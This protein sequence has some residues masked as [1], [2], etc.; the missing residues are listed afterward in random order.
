MRLISIA[1]V[2]IIAMTLAACSSHQRERAQLM[3]FWE[4]TDAKKIGSVEFQPDDTV[5]LSGSAYDLLDWKVMNLFRDFHMTPGIKTM[6]FQMVDKDQI[7]IQGDFTALLA[8]LSDGA[9]PGSSV[10]LDTDEY[11]PSSTLSF[12]VSGNTLTLTP[13]KG[14]AMTF[15]R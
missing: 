13:R 9:P 5:V 4:S 10:Q 8:Q 7:E 1:G 6:K 14:K 12:A 15:K 3:G 11:R 2:A